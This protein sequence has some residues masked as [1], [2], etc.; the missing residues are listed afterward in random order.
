M[1]RGLDT[2]REY[3]RGFENQ[4]VLIGGAACDILFA[5]NEGQFRATRDLDMVLIVEALTPEFGEK[6]WEF[7]EAGQYRNK[8]TSAGKPQFYIFDKP[9][10]EAYPKMIELFART[11]FELKEMDGLTPIHIDDEVSSLSAILL[12]EDYY[13]VLLAGREVVQELSVLR[14]EYLIL[15]KAKAYLDLSDR[16]EK[17]ENVDSRDIRKHKND[18]LRIAVEFVLES[19]TTLPTTVI[20]DMEQFI[21]RLE[22]EPFDAGVLKNYGVGNEELVDNLRKLYNMSSN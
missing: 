8:A 21:I 9:E 22:A 5:N 3:F 16:K 17:G 15:F 13:N 2:F 4:Y 14:P 10:K 1:V 6:F 12:N 20:K 7:V 19:V 18:I 11:D